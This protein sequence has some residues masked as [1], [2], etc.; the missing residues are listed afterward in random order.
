M[1]RCLPLIDIEI[2]LLVLQP[3]EHGRV[4]SGYSVGL[5]LALTLVEAGGHGGVSDLA[6]FRCSARVQVAVRFVGGCGHELLLTRGEDVRH[7]RE[8]DLVCLLD[9]GA[10]LCHQ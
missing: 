9:L 7:F 5:A 8:Q 1:S 2:G 3:I 6:E 10:T 4:L